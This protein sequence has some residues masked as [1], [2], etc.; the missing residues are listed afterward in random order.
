VNIINRCQST[1]YVLITMVVSLRETTFF[2]MEMMITNLTTRHLT[3]YSRG[4][5]E[6]LYSLDNFVTRTFDNDHMRE[7]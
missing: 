3:F 7:L 1:E 6:R 5:K 2:R 4:P